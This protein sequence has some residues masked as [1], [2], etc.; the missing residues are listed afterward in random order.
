MRTIPN[1]GITIQ[2]ISSFKNHIRLDSYAVKYISATPVSPEITTYVLDI[3]KA[4]ISM[5][6]MIKA[7]HI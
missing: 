4:N 6:I 1:M 5:F 2:M 3:G 7:E